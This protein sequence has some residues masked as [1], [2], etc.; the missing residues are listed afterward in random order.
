M[1]ANFTGETA[2]TRA[3]TLHRC[4]WCTGDI[5]PGSPC[6]RLSWRYDGC[7]DLYYVHHDCNEAWLRDRCTREGE[8][9]T[10]QHRQGMTCDETAAADEQET[11]L[12]C[13]KQEPRKTC[14]HPHGGGRHAAR[15]Q[16]IP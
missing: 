10:Y 1:P 13:W 3:R 16:V 4:M 5:P 2:I 9:C 15:R 11:A 12:A 7:V 8:E 14:R 6:L